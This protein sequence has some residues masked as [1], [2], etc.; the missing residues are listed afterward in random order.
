MPHSRLSNAVHGAFH[1]P[2]TQRYL[3]VQGVVWAL[4]VVSIGLLAVDGALGP[5]HPAAAK[6][7]LMDSVLLTIFVLELILRIGSYR[8]P[9]LEVFDRP[10]LG[11]LRTHTTSRLRF[12]LRPIQLVDILAVMALFPGLRGLRA[13]R[14]LR[15]LRTTQFFRYGNPFAT[16]IN[17]IES[18]GLLF[19]FAMLIL[20]SETVIGGVTFFLIEAAHRPDATLAEGIWWALVT[21]TTVG[22]G[23]VTPTTALSR[24]VGGVLMVGGMVTLALFAGI[25]SQSLVTAVSAIRE[26]QFRMSDYAN[27]VVVC[28]YDAT[29][30]LLLE[31]LTEE[32]NLQTT[33]V[34][35][36][37]DRDQP[38]ELPT[39]FLWMRGDPTKQSELDKVRLTH[40][41]AVIVSGSRGERPQIADAKT[42]LTVFTIRSYLEAHERDV[43]HRRSPLY[44]VAEILDTENVSHALTAGAN[45]VVETRRMG[46]LML[47][48][49]VRFHGS[50]DVM[51]HMLVKGRHN[52]Y[53][54][55][56]PGQLQEPVPY[57]QLMRSLGLAQQG[58]LV[59]GLRFPDGEEVINP[60][61]SVEVVPG[62]LL[63][64]LSEQPVLKAPS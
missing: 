13:L 59:I 22:Y 30:N 14:L 23:D 17:A 16:V 64:Y 15:L 41:S 39:A 11:Q 26:E 55:Q 46:S 18:N 28:G 10:P 48:H 31:A 9:A 27:H 40:A 57:A 49:A 61:G 33:R 20:F 38:R 5:Q 52:V 54:G 47:A 51:S 58:A 2:T 8:P 62:T 53:V 1:V 44:V 45:E 29:T 36:F 56:I 32:M 43:R 6:L 50:A 7:Q 63:V 34:V 3:V 19:S 60:R 42:I 37:A 35:I 21:I 24:V 4:I 25:I 12:A